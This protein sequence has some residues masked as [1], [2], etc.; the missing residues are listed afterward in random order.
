MDIKQLESILSKLKD[1]SILVL[2]DYFLDKYLLLDPLLNEESIETGLAAY[3]VVGKKLS[4]GAAG[5]VTNNLRALGV[6]KVTALGVAGKDGE[7]CELINGLQVTG[8]LTDN[9]I[10]TE[11][12][13]TPTYIKPMKMDIAESREIN[14]IDIKNRMPT[15]GWIEDLIIE[16]LLKLSCEVD[17]IIVMDQV[18]EKDCGTVTERVRK[19]LAE[20]GRTRNDLLVYA[21]SRAFTYLFDNILI[22]CNHYELLQAFHYGSDKEHEEDL[23]RKC[24]VML[25]LKNNRP[26][27]V[28]MGSKGQMVFDGEKVTEVPAVPAEGPLDIC[29]A[30]DAT[31]S[32]II[33]ALCCGA[34]YRDAALL[35]NTVAS[36]TI[37]Q[38][39]TTGTASP[40]QVLARF[41]EFSQISNLG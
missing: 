34:S 27:F 24:G 11:E 14:R 35:G 16:Q 26:V 2:G 10:I 9:M 29:G 5:T 32:G 13:F 30:G 41:R 36:I 7:G 23:I 20:L 3:Q 22:K 15:P 25:S 33:S 4:P 17:A 1:I 21:D 38:L 19:V 39:G 28:T 12:R 18:T 31:T 6:G 8:V 37:Q 40:E